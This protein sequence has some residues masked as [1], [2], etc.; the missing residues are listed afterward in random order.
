MSGSSLLPIVACG[1]VSGAVCLPAYGICFA[2]A[3]R[4]VKSRGGGQAA[5]LLAGTLLAMLTCG[6]V[7]ALPLWLADLLPLQ[8]Q[9]RNWVLAFFAGIGTS[10][11]L[12]FLLHR[13][14]TRT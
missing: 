9:S 4:R 10:K 8:T 5:W 7:V 3:A 14:P 13:T 12:A 1:L 6:V 11:A 2:V